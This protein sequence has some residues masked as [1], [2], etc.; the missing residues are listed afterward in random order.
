MA[1]VRTVE[2][3]T[4]VLGSTQPEDLVDHARLSEQGVQLRRRRGGGGAVFLPSNGCL[5]VDAWVPRVDPLWDPDVSTAAAWAGSWWVSA[6][7]SGGFGS[8]GASFDVHQGR[9]DPGVLGELICFSGRG[10]GEVFCDGRKVVGLS[11]WRSRQGALFSM[12]AYEHWDP[13]PL[14]ALLR[15]LGAGGPRRGLGLDDVA[16]GVGDL[17]GGCGELAVLRDALVNSFSAW[18]G[19][20]GIQAG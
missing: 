9:A 11:Q 15:P 5:W 4:L 7:V 13:T 20:D 1:V 10:P 14:V 8:A 19:D 18:G 3:P 6:L 16:V 17:A 2:H 12:C